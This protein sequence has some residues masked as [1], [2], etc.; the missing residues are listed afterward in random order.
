MV[1]NDQ[2]HVFRRKPEEEKPVMQMI[3]IRTR[4]KFRKVLAGRS[5]IWRD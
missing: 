5:S 2:D 1:G 3:V 4:K